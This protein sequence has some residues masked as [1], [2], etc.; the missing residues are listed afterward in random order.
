[1]NAVQCP[2][3]RTD[4]LQFLAAVITTARHSGN[5]ALRLKGC[6]VDFF[7]F[8]GLFDNLDDQATHFEKDGHELSRRSKHLEN[9][10]DIV[11]ELENSAVGPAEVADVQLVDDTA[12]GIQSR[13][14]QHWI[15]AI[16]ARELKG[17]HVVDDDFVLSLQV[18]LE[19]GDRG[20]NLGLSEIDKAFERISAKEAVV[21]QLYKEVLV[22]SHAHEELEL[23]VDLSLSLT[24][25]M[26]GDVGLHHDAKDELISLVLGVVLKGATDGVSL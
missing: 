20:A 5:R 26:D 16:L 23:G 6:L 3:S 12:P 21:V 13:F 4:R 11:E 2:E 25:H 7:D 17:A 8:L 18:E 9:W 19:L 22:G 14:Q 24:R 1:M 10:K 15:Q